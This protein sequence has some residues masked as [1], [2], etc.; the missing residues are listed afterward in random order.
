MTEVF[1]AII[2]FVNSTFIMEMDPLAG[3]FTPEHLADNLRHGF[4]NSASEVSSPDYIASHG[5][6]GNTITDTGNL[7]HQAIRRKRDRRP[8]SSSYHSIPTEN[9]T[10]QRHHRRSNAVAIPV[11]QLLS[12]SRPKYLRSQSGNPIV[13]PRVCRHDCHARR[14]ALQDSANGTPM[15]ADGTGTPSRKYQSYKPSKPDAYSFYQRASRNFCAETCEDDMAFEPRI[16]SYMLLQH[17]SVSF[18]CTIRW[19]SRLIRDRTIPVSRSHIRRLW[20]RISFGNSNSLDRQDIIVSFE[21]C[22]SP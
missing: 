11:G 6:N 13:L 1:T 7:Y 12:P 19:I 20:V 9:V 3:E 8:S 2:L 4:S 15:S 21:S 22:W 16:C 17:S 18:Q 14:Q 5:R 10:H